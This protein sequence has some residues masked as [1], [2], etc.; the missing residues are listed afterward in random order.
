MSTKQE[1]HKFRPRQ[2]RYGLF[3]RVA[4][5]LAIFAL[6]SVIGVVFLGARAAGGGFGPPGP[7]RR[8][9]LM[10]GRLIE[11]LAAYYTGAG[12]SWE[13]VDAWL[14]H[15]YVAEGRDDRL[16]Q[17]ALLADATGQVVA[18]PG[19]KRLGQTLSP[20]ELERGFPIVVD[21]RRVGA[22]IVDM[23]PNFFFF[24]PILD[25]LA[26]VGLVVGGVALVG[27]VI[28][29]RR[30]TA[31][32]A[33]VVEAAETLAAG[34]LNA[35]VAV[36]G[37]DEV[38]HLA[39]AFN[40]MAVKLQRTDELRRNLTADVA[41][42]L[43]IPLTIIQANLEGILDGIYPATPEHLEP[44]L[45]ET[46]L[47]SRLVEDLHLLSLAE[48]GQLFLEQRAVDVGGLLL[49]TARTFQAQADEQGITLSVQVPEQ[50]PQALIDP[51]RIG[52]VLGNLMGN[53]LS[54]TPPGGKITLAAR[55]QEDGEGE[56]KITI[57]VSDT[58]SGIPP[59]D[60]PYI[61]DR[62]WK[63]DHSCPRTSGGAGLGLA[64][65]RQLVEAQG[66]QIWATNDEGGGTT[67]SFT[68]PA[69]EVE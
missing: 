27:S 4:G 61:F 21:G 54:Y 18:D 28:V 36:R 3:L 12:G 53:A 7:P 19:G 34:D 39:E 13:G 9:S 62:F 10:A 33:D 40:Q 44:I 8:D 46:R 24:G 41:H 66:G 63:G 52:Q 31:P 57:S 14:I 5:L 17:H 56:K 64:I 23:S 20:G 32:I 22:L 59:A 51:Q 2:A 30:V 35:R 42:E 50:L 60:L 15:S 1:Q 58:G 29:S 67:L 43:R 25:T 16:W 69:V 45:E 6:C 48:A 65:A 37:H 49:D 26:I 47:L 11:P 55:P 68:M 38:A